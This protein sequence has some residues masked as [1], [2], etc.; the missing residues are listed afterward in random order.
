MTCVVDISAIKDEIEK[1]DGSIQ[2]QV[3][4]KIDQ[5]KE[6]PEKGQTKS[7]RLAEPGLRVVKVNKQRIVM[8][9]HKPSGKAHSIY[10]WDE[11][12]AIFSRINTLK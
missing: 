11:S 10:G 1:L 9:Y 6:N 7:H 8:F 3:H 12:E 2:I 4:K 5:V